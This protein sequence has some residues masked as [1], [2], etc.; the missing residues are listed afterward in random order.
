[1]L[2]QKSLFFNF[3]KKCDQ[4]YASGTIFL[5]SLSKLHKKIIQKSENQ[6]KKLLLND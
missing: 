4:F 5:R 6:K 3:R 2:K 1:M